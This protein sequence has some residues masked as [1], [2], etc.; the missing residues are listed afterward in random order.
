MTLGLNKFC[1]SLFPQ[2]LFSKPRPPP[3]LVKL[4]ATPVIIHRS[5]LAKHEFENCNIWA[6]GSILFITLLQVFACLVGSFG[7]KI[8]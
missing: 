3:N 6:P 1:F 7:I 5:N 2:E 8:R 4:H